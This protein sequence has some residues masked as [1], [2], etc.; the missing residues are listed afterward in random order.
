MKNGG[1]FSILQFACLQRAIEV[2]VAVGHDLLLVRLA[3]EEN[4]VT[5]EE[6]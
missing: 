4:R 2:V 3:N 1:S 5:K 6:C